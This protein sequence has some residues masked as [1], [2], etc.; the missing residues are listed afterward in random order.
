MKTVKSNQT[1]VTKKIF[2]NHLHL[3]LLSSKNSVSFK[4]TMA[5]D[6][7]NIDVI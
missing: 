1:K 4:P 7:K 6:G 3:G 5:V 2:G